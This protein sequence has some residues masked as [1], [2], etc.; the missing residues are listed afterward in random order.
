M[1]YD[2]KVAFSS[3]GLG[4]FALL[5]IPLGYNFECGANGVTES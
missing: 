2:L 4:N 1:I 5:G 3:K